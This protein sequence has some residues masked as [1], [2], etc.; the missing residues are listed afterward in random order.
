ML[1]VARQLGLNNPIDIS[2]TLLAAHAVPPEYR[3]DPDAY[4]TLVCEQI[5]LNAVAKELYEAVDVFCENVGFTPSQTERL[6]KA[7]AALGYPGE[8]AC[9]TAVESGRRGAGQPV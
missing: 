8:R 3:Q 1:Q 6:F 4:L 9:R 7:A 5:L 2:P